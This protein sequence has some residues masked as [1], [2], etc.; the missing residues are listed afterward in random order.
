VYKTPNYKTKRRGK[1]KNMSKH[2]TK[3]LDYHQEMMKSKYGVDLS[4]RKDVVS[5]TLL[6]SLKRFYTEEFSKRFE[7]SKSEKASSYLEKISSFCNEVFQEK[8]DLI[9]SWEL[10][11]D[12]IKDFMA[13][14]V[15]PTHIKFTLQKESDLRLYKDFY[16]C[17]YQYSH[18][19]LKTMLKEKVCGFL[20]HEFKMDG[21]LTNFIKQCP[22]MSKHSET[23]E[24]MSS[25]FIQT[26]L[27][28]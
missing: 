25:T 12:E 23:Y 6:R 14:I 20:F 11:L 24:E 4:I 22:T 9:R 15:S 2:S 8:T 7:L 3:N 21:H 18:R 28:N 16:S 1:A 5:K 13:I 17:L 10:S 27:I 19:K 26:I